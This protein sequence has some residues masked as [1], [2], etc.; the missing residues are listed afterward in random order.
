VAA[1]HLKRDLKLLEEV[2]SR[3]SALLSDD[4]VVGVHLAELRS[5]LM[6]QNLSRL[7]EPYSTVEITHLAS[8]INLPEK[9]VEAKLSQMILDKKL[10]GVLDQGT[11]WLIVFEDDDDA[12]GKAY[13]KVLNIIASMGNV[14][15]ALYARGS[16]LHA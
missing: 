4:A 16:K 2:V 15:D 1:A 12:K 13:P 5:D 14:V 10:A 9:V 6:E 7:I 11:G 3:S 8:L